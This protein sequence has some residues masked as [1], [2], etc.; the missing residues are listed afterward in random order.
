[1]LLTVF[2]LVIDIGDSYAEQA[3][4]VQSGLDAV[5]KGDKLGAIL[6]VA[7]GWKGGNA[8]SDDLIA[9]SE[10][11]WQQSVWTS[12][13]CSKIAAKSL[14]KSSLLALTGAVPALGGTPS[15]LGYGMAKAAVHQLVKSLSQEG[16]GL[17]EGVKT[18]AILPVTLDTPMNRK[19]MPDADTSTW[20]PLETIAKLFYDWATNAVPAVNGSLVQLITKNNETSFVVE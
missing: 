15:M 8:A 3:T 12:V 1:M 16:S 19:F 20:T 9:S 18:V 10:I 11:M 14:E 13:I 6:C 17:A 7:G 4:K 5:L 2:I